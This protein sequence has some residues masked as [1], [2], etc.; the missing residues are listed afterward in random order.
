MDAWSWSIR[1]CRVAI[2]FFCAGYR[3]GFRCGVA[4]SRRWIRILREVFVGY[5]AW[6]RRR[7]CIVGVLL[8]PILA[9]NVAERLPIAG[10]VHQERDCQGPQ[11]YSMHHSALH[12]PP[13]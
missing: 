12:N 5:Y 3:A 4:R 10:R 13:V 7:R 2:L 11:E 1:A 8:L 9:R 6:L